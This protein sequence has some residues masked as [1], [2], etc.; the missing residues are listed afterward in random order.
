MK[1]T[2]MISNIVNSVILLILF[3]GFFHSCSCLCDDEKKKEKEQ[4]ISF[5][6]NGQQVMYSEQDKAFH[7]IFFGMSKSFADQQAKNIDV[8]INDIQYHPLLLYSED[9]KLID[10]YLISD[11]ISYHDY[12]MVASEFGQ[13]L[14]KKYGEPSYNNPEDAS[15]HNYSLSIPNKSRINGSVI[16]WGKGWYVNERKKVFM[17]HEFIDNQIQ[18]HALDSSR[19]WIWIFNQ[20]HYVPTSFEDIENQI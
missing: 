15:M 20:N 4:M 19:I 18:F 12:K 2:K 8:S 1:T 9:N 16:H 7:D 13:I 11:T 3:L 6:E 5:N 10:A 14:T 17:G